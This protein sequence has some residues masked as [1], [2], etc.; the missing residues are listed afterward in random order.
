MLFRALPGDGLVLHAETAATS[1]EDFFS[2]VL[3]QR[4]IWETDFIVNVA[5]KMLFNIR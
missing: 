2:T 3:P 1:Q 5:G 4:N